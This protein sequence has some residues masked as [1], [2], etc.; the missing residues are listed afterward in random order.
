MGQAKGTGMFCIQ[1]VLGD[2]WLLRMMTGRGEECGRE[3]Y[4]MVD[5]EDRGRGEARRGEVRWMNVEGRGAV[6]GRRLA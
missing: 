3:V 2:G 5:Y 4:L 6:R 1:P